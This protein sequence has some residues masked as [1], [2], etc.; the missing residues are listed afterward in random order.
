MK[1][2]GLSFPYNFMAIFGFH[3]AV[4]NYVK[5]AQEFSDRLVNRNKH[6]GDGT[7]TAQEFREKFLFAF[8]DP[9]IWEEDTPTITFDFEGVDKISP[10]FAREAF[11]N[12]L[13]YTSKENLLKHFLFV[14]ITKVKMGIIEGELDDN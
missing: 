13:Q 12:F 3:R 14:N 10:G 8:D 5:V 2:K 7:F 11:A 6:Q 1:S 9:Y 4:P